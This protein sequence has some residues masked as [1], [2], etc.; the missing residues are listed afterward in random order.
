M[1]PGEADI[2]ALRLAMPRFS[3]EWKLRGLC[4]PRETGVVTGS[5]SM[6]DFSLKPSAP[7]LVMADSKALRACPAGETFPAAPPRLGFGSQR[8]I[9]CAGGAGG[10]GGAGPP[11][12][13]GVRGRVLGDNFDDRFSKVI[14]PSCSAVGWGRMHQHHGFKVLIRS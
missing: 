9:S 4:P 7:P 5:A 1:S 11:P 6:T 13:G 12:R 14:H 10:G 2:D 8:L 3:S